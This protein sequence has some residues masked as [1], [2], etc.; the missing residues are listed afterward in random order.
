MKT[1]VD[2]VQFPVLYQS[3]SPVRESSP[4]NTVG[5]F[6]L[7][8]RLLLGSPDRLQAFVCSVIILLVDNLS[9]ESILIM[10]SVLS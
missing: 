1:A 5:P 6:H 7:H 10:S 4:Q 8:K 2:D 9:F 3:M